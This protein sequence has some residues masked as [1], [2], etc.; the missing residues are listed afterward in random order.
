MELIQKNIIYDSMLKSA[1]KRALHKCKQVV[2]TMP[3]ANPDI[4]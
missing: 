2:K 1:E 4:S 3:S